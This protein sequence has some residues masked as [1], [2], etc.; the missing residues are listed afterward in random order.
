VTYLTSRIMGDI[1]EDDVEE[2]QVS[3]R[4]IERQTTRPWID[5]ESNTGENRIGWT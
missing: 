1:R 2:L 3:P 5:K 4:I